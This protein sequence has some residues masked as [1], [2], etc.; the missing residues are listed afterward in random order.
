MKRKLLQLAVLIGTVSATGWLLAGEHEGE[1]RSKALAPVS[2]PKWQAECSACHTLYHPGLLPERSWRRVMGSLDKHFG[3]NA[4]LD[5]VTQKEITAFLA[6]NAA[7]HADSRRSAK[8]AQSIPAGAAPLRITETAWFVRKHDEIRPDIWKRP[9]VGSAANCA[10]CH[11][12]A[13]KGDF[14]EAN[15]RIPR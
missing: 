5:P 8:I 14:A 15:V 4:S 1:S 13:E 9:K 11:S 7:D 3:E 2:N 12:G 6:A 10:A